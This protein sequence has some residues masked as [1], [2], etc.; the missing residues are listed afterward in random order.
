MKTQSEKMN[1]LNIAAEK[2]ENTINARTW[3]A[4]K[5][6][7]AARLF[8]INAATAILE[9]L[10]NAVEHTDNE[11]AIFDTAAEY[12]HGLFIAQFNAEIKARATFEARFSDIKAA[13]T[14]AVLAAAVGK[15][16]FDFAA[17]VRGCYAEIGRAARAAR[18]VAYKERTAAAAEKA[19]TKSKNARK[20]AAR[21][22]ARAAEIT[23]N[24]NA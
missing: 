23:G 10:N 18:A 7:A 13:A 24:N 2:A 5:N 3:E 20:R 21:A 9:Y 15:R 14:P 6:N 22:A 19:E 11:K 8:A 4:H 16:G 12:L 1:A 17:A